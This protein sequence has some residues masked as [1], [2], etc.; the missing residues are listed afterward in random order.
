MVSYIYKGDSMRA[1]SLAALLGVKQ[2]DVWNA[3]F[4]RWD[5]Y[6]QGLP[7][8]AGLMVN[9]GDEVSF[10]GQEVSHPW[11][12]PYQQLPPPGHGQVW[13]GWPLL[14]TGITTVGA[15]LIAIAV[16]GR[17]TK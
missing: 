15:I 2:V 3:Y 16:S 10:A 13:R 6:Y 4:D 5:S 7:F 1:S 12:E 14:V 9:P 11:L 8:N 17:A